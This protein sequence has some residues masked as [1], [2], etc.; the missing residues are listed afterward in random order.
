MLTALAALTLGSTAT[1]PLR[2]PAE[3][4]PQEAVLISWPTYDHVQ[5]M[6]VSDVHVRI[7]QSLTPHVRVDI[8]VRNAQEERA[9]RA[10]LRRGGVTQNIRFMRSPN[11]EIWVRDF[12]PIFTFQPNGQR[13]IVDFGFDY[14]G[15]STPADPLAKRETSTESAVAKAMNLPIVKA[16]LVSEGGN[17]ESNGRGTL[18]MVESVERDRNPRLNRLQIE[19]EYRRV[20]GTRNFLWIPRGVLDDGYTFDGPL[21]NGSYT[22]I[23]TGGHVDN[24]AR[25]VD[26]RTL[27]VA[28]VTAAEAKNDPLA[29][30]NRR[31]TEEAVAILREAR[32]EDGEPFRIIRMPSPD[33]ILRTMRPGDPVYDF[34]STL[35]YRS[36]VPF[37]K[38]KPVQVAFATS[39]M[40]FLITN[41]AVLTSRFYKPGRNLALKRKDEQAIATLRRVFPGRKIIAIDSDAVNLGG[42]GLHCITQPIFR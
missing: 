42:G 13:T 17:R 12:G 37:P 32:T 21:P 31:R 24:I 5:N 30:E 27:L 6:P 41:G 4:E 19:D 23:T 26:R 40:N 34:I 7:A 16:N 20:F 11:A 25:F 33:P 9:A 28:E 10:Q 14:W 18:M 36:G 22:P 2:L 35:E 8:L 3:W 15:Y 29:A 39:Y 38:G 1:L